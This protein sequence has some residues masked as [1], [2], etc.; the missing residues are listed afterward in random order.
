MSRLSLRD[1]PARSHP[2]R[3]VEG[4]RCELRV[5]L[6]NLA[7]IDATI[8]WTLDCMIAIGPAARFGE[9]RLFVRDARA[10]MPEQAMFD[11]A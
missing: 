1:S 5:E 6:P 4:F 2:R 9:N 3:I 8:E 10:V 11:Q 7:R